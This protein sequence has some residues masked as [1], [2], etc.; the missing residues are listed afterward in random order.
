MS[1]K[2]EKITRNQRKAITASLKYPTVEQAAGAIG[3]N[4]RTV[5]RWLD[6]PGFRLALSQ[7]EGEALDKIGRR[8]LVMS[9]QALSAI[10]DILDDPDKPGNTNL[11]LAAGL[12][13]NQTMRLRELRN[14]ESRL[15]DLEKAVF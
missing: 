14:I 11:R 4:S 15:S 10:Q 12:I 7:A 5:F 2:A 8:L 3:V 9:D 13:L 6:D 1:Q